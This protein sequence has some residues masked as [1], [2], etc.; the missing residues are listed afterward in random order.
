MR[1][2]LGILKEGV[3]LSTIPVTAFVYDED[4]TE[5]CKANP[6]WKGRRARIESGIQ[7]CPSLRKIGALE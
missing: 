2:E 6:G 4:Y 5:S 3:Q 1:R 7:T